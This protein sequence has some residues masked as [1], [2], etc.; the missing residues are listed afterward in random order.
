MLRLPH[1]RKSQI[2]LAA[3]LA[4]L[5]VFATAVWGV[6]QY[7]NQ[8]T[9]NAA[10]EEAVIGNDIEETN[11]LLK[12]GANANGHIPFGVETNSGYRPLVHAIEQ[13]NVDMMRLLLDYG[14]DI[15]ISP[16]YYESAVRWAL[17]FCNRDAAAYLVYV[18]PGF[19][20][21]RE[22]VNELLLLSAECGAIELVEY[23]IQHGA[24]PAGTANKAGDKRSTPLNQAVMNEHTAVVSVL[25]EHGA[26][27]NTVATGYPRGTPLAIACNFG[28]LE[29]VRHLLDLGA[30][31]NVSSRGMTPLHYAVSVDEPE[32][33]RVLLDAGADPS[34]TDSEGRTA[35]TIA[36]LEGRSEIVEL[37]ENWEPDATI[38][39]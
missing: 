13:N 39:E 15:Y 4:F 2:R 23:W 20:V 19:D 8:V 12:A 25:I 16:Q 22:D 3:V 28:P 29:M 1:D 10:L 26:P 21:A 11:R 36:K 14:A 32:F 5:A 27:L 37:F 33:V 18:A 30:D 35:L 17:Y 31:P 9:L 24:D 6:A 7:F 34:L 38:E